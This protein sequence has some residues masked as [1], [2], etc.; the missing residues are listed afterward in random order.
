VRE[1]PRDRW[2][3]HPNWPEQTLLLNSH[4]GF[5]RMCSWLIESVHELDLTSDSPLRGRK[6]VV[7]LRMLFDQWQAGMGGHERYEEKKLYPYLGRKYGVAFDHLERGHHELHIA[8]DEVIVKFRMAAASGAGHPE[9]DQL[10]ETLD[11]YNGILVEHLRVEE[12]LVIP[13]LLTLS[14]DEFREYSTHS[15][16]DLLRRMRERGE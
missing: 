15:L 6:R 4:D 2:K 10:G 7:L 3:E 8:R 12:E 9:R 11:S 1:W 16:R 5:R 14:P 13:L